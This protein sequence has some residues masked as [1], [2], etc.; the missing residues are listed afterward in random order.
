MRL[1]PSIKGALSTTL[2]A[3]GMYI[4]ENE[5]IQYIC[6]ASKRR[7]KRMY[8]ESSHLSN[9]EKGGTHKHRK[10]KTVPSYLSLHP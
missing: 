3:G 10:H 8:N 2:E 1:G 5:S 6:E 4:V 9:R 7:R